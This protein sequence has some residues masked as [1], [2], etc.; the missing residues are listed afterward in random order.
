MVPSLV[1]TSET[2]ASLESPSFATLDRIFSRFAPDG[3][4][5]SYKRNANY[6][7]AIIVPYRDRESHLRTFLYNIIPFLE[8]Q[9]AS[10]TIFI[11]EQIAN[12]TFNKGLLTNVG[13]LYA[14]RS[15]EKF[16]C[17]IFHD[18]DLLPED[19]R[20]I[21]RCGKQPRHFAAGINK[22][23]YK[24]PYEGYVG[25][26]IG[27]TGYQYRK[28]N[29]YS[30]AYWGWGGE[31]DDINY[32]IGRAGFTVSRY[33]D[34]VC[35]YTMIKHEADLGNEVNPC[36]YKLLEDWRKRMYTDGVNSAVYKLVLVEKLAFF[37]KL[38]VDAL[39]EVNKK[40]Y[41]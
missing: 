36:R 10:Y 30:N 2:A 3:K 6:S 4:F 5:E 15:A 28:V 24:L 33:R 12:Q 21:Y 1:A 34:P 27:L 19:D 37:T 20:N 22:F 26:V 11:V 40:K 38:M 17:F 16:S 13:F 39:P 9:E 18:V 32:R 35:R 8:N 41:C 23:N 7:V 14:E 29:G 31:D 25:G